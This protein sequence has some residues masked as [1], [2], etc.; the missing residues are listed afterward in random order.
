MGTSQFGVNSGVLVSLNQ[1][2]KLAG[3]QNTFRQLPKQFD[4]DQRSQ[5]L[6]RSSESRASGSY[7]Q[8]RLWTYVTGCRS[9][10]KQARKGLHASTFF[11]VGDFMFARS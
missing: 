4:E 7:D 6:P 11:F 8:D 1:H 2:E 10:G 9:R 5:G 3:S